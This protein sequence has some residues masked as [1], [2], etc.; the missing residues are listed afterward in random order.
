MPIP[1][2]VDSSDGVR[3]AV[4]DLGG[5]GPLVL[6]CHATGFHGHVYGP[7]AQHLTDSYHCV[8][9]DFRGHGASPLPEGATLAWTAMVNDLSAVVAAIRQ[10]NPDIGPIRAVGHSLGGGVIAV[11]EASQP[12]TFESAWCFEPV[13][14]PD[15]VGEVP[16]A[17]ISDAARA[18]RRVFDSRDAAFERYQSRP[19]F[20]SVTSESLRAYVEHG[21]HDLPDGTVTLACAPETE[22]E[23]FDQAHK[24]ASESAAAKLTIP[25]AIASGTDTEGVAIYARDVANRYD[26]LTLI[27]MDLNHFGP[28]QDP[29]AVADSIREWFSIH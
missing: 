5:E 9:L 13:L 22:G 6:F 17:P 19:P 12:G 24:S 10:A 25:Y 3:I 20:N 7:V 8:A 11:T 28:L 16:K 4:H 21:F 23:V 27:D 26:N 1:T 18:R 29:K 15:P 14:L 2:Y